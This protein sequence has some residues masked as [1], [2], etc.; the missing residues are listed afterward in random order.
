MSSKGSDGSPGDADDGS[1]QAGFLLAEV[2]V[3]MVV[4][5]LFLGVLGRAF[6]L[7]WGASH[8][9]MEIMSAMAVARA[10]AAASGDQT[11]GDSG[12]LG[13]FS[14][15]RSSGSV[16]MVAQPSRLA[17]APLGPANSAQPPKANPL[18]ASVKASVAPP[19]QLR[20][21]S[22]MVRAPSGR[23]LTLDSIRLDAAT[24]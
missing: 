12:R 13:K 7:A 15:E 3:A 19:L 23:R 8:S 6:S 10:S 22:V 11:L 14:F 20:R 9:P 4:A 21:I 5:G 2:L 18:N 24:N 1:A 17:P 16:T